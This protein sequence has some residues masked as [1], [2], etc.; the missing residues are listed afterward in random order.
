MEQIW[1]HAIWN[2]N[3]TFSQRYAFKHFLRFSCLKS[4]IQTCISKLKL[5][6]NIFLF[7]TKWKVLKKSHEIFLFHLNM[8]FY[9]PL[10]TVSHCLRRWLKINHKSLT[11]SS[12]DQ[13]GICIN[14]SIKLEYQTFFP[15]QDIKSWEGK[16]VWY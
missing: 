3:T 13:R 9:F 12:I 5:V 1:I 2:M 16:K 6:S 8:L 4:A 10:P 7:F 11:T 15:C 14:I